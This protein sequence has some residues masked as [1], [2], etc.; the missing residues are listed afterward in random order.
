MVPYRK[1]LGDT[2]IV[3]EQFYFYGDEDGRMSYNSFLGNFKDGKWKIESGGK[4]W[5]KISSTTGKP[6]IVFANLPVEG[7]GEDE[8]AQAE[9]NKY[10]QNNHIIP[11]VIVHRGHSYHLS[12]TLEHLT[13]STRIVMLG[14]CGG[15]HNLGTVLDASPDAQ[16]ISTKQVGTMSVN[17][18]IIKEINT[19]LLA[20]Q[21]VDWINSWHNLDTY[22]ARVKGEPQN[23]FRDYVPPHR[24]LGAIFIKAYR[25]ISNAEQA[26]EE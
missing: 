8:K 22:F 2:T 18:P 16:I 9:L 3:F 26:N 17:E 23:R 5:V 13:K 19:Q 20:G 1:L 6:V 7:E 14:S 12:S 24:N 25:R 21:D 4:S 15:Y 11:T 10:L